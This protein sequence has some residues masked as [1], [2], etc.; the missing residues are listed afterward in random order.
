[1]PRL[2]YSVTTYKGPSNNSNV[3]LPDREDLTTN[4]L[5]EL[6]EPIKYLHLHSIVGTNPPENI[7]DINLS[8]KSF[9]LDTIQSGDQGASIWFKKDNNNHTESNC[10]LLVRAHVTS[11]GIYGY[12]LS[13]G[14]NA[15]VP[16]LNLVRLDNNV[17]VQIFSITPSTSPTD[18][19]WSDNSGCHIFLKA[20]NIEGGETV[21]KTYLHNKT[22]DT[23]ITEFEGIDP[24]VGTKGLLGDGY[25]GFMYAITSGG[26]SGGIKFYEFVAYNIYSDVIV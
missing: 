15:S 25:P 3:Y 23:W 21:I 22:T 16:K 14:F 19:G 1:M 13:Y 17:A 10:A 8:G 24:E 9:I 5:T 26:S 6:G 18:T 20:Y 11:I 4:E 12:M 2:E 7:G